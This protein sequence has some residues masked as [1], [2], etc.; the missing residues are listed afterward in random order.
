MQEFIFALWLLL[1]CKFLNHRFLSLL[2]C[3]LCRQSCWGDV[4]GTDIG[5][6]SVTLS[7]LPPSLTLFGTEA[8]LSL[9]CSYAEIHSLVLVGLPVAGIAPSPQ[10]D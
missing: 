5:M 1:L 8:G 6:L 9:F 3:P 2:L 4:G 10:P 7:L